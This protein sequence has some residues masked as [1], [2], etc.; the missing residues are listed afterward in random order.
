MSASVAARRIGREGE[1]VAIVDGFHPGPAALR[2]SANAARFAVADRHYPGVRAPLGPETLLPVRDLIAALFA[3]VFGCG[4]AAAVLDLGFS[5]V[6]TPPSQLNLVQRLPHVDAIK[7]GR[8]AMVLYLFDDETGG[9]AFYRH[10]ATGFETLNAERSAT[11]FEALTA[12]IAAAPPPPAYPG[13]L[14][15]FDV[16]DR[17][18]ARTNRAVFYRSR[19]LH[20][21]IVTPKTP[22]VPDPRTGRLTITGFFDAS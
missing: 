11:Y 4:E 20:S 22:L 19:L 14:P 1:P 7:P 15:Q 18:P 17:V 21:G 6:A 5:I 3:E 12:E 16:V 9:T 8:I 10:R 2:T 13:A